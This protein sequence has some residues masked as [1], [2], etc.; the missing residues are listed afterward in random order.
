MAVMTA[1]AVLE[2]GGLAHLSEVAMNNHTHISKWNIS[3]RWM[4]T[5][6]QILARWAHLLGLR[7]GMTSVQ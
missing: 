1:L 3:T 6:E 4:E 2:N 5:G 7:V